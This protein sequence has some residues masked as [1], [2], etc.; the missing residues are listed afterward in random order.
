MRLL[1]QKL[2]SKANQLP[3]TTFRILQRIDVNIE[4]YNENT[5]KLIAFYT[6]SEKAK[7]KKVDYKKYLN[8]IIRK[9]SV[10]QKKYTPMFANF[11]RLTVY[12]Q[13][14]ESKD[15]PKPL[16]TLINE[17]P[18][19]IILGVAGSGK[20]TTLSKIALENAKRAFLKSICS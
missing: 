10:W 3:E 16:T 6:K 14:I 12:A 13:V 7:K 5:K 2:A 20:T 1:H 17:T 9:H 8:E 19:L 11:E 15:V 4:E 18:K